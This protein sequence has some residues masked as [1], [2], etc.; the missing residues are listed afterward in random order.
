MPKPTTISTGRMIG[1]TFISCSIIIIQSQRRKNSRTT[2]MNP[3]QKSCL[4]S[5]ELL[6]RKLE[7][8]RKTTR[9]VIPAT[10]K[11]A[12]YIGQPLTITM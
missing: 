10:V 8:G 12:L 2:L 9:P 6:I 4:S 11:N 3:P 7:T 1:E 5:S